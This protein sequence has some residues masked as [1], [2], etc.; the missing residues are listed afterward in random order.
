M[1][2]RYIDYTKRPKLKENQLGI[3]KIYA[4]CQK[5]RQ[6]A[7][8]PGESAAGVTICLWE[9]TQ[10][11]ATS[12][13]QKLPQLYLVVAGRVQLE[14]CSHIVKVSVEATCFKIWHILKGMT[15]PTGLFGNMP[16]PGILERVVN[17]VALSNS[18]AEKCR[19][20]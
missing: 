20:I 7:L 4:F 12:P 10:K 17:Q 16:H 11:V 1:S 5:I 15:N 3:L 8:F 9:Y 19:P 13:L 14:H 2:P 18:T 6:R